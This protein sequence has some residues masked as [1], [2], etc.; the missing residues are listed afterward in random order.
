MLSEIFYW[1][2]NVSI[3]GSVTGLIILALRKV[4]KLPKFA[5]YVLWTIP[6][7]RLWI[8][9][10]IANKY[11]LVSFVSKF[12]T[13]TVIMWSDLP[14]F[15]MA[16]SIMS[17]K[18][19]FPIK[20]KTYMIT[21]IFYV[22]SVVWIMVAIAAILGAIIFYILTKTELKT[23]EHIKDNIYMSDKITTPAVYGI[24]KPKI[25]IPVAITDGAIEY[26]I[27]HEMVHIKR[28]DNLFRIVA[29]ITVC[30]HWFNPLSWIFLKC[31]FADMELACDTKVLK[32]LDEKQTKNYANAILSCA[33]GK[34]LFASAFGGAKTKF[35]IENVLSYRKLTL[36]SSLCVV[37]LVVVIMVVLITNGVGKG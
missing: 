2:L 32:R 37:A 34:A 21:Q 36:F 13:K 4:K 5:V 7:L 15:T 24:I 17:A 9:F 8:P 35:R 3:I 27:M 18:S 31:F 6:L 10:S 14:E 11:S 20:Y 25:I 26:I 16:N 12:T 33:S 28:K 19:Y 30:V 1:V 29:V 22:S 23:A